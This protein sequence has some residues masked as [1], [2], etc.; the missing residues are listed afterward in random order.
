MLNISL[1]ITKSDYM[2]LRMIATPLA[3]S[4]TA[5]LILQMTTTLAN[6]SNMKNSVMLDQRVCIESGLVV[7]LNVER[8]GDRWAMAIYGKI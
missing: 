8:G 2:P 1:I 7:V 5:D 4:L 3:Q 6:L